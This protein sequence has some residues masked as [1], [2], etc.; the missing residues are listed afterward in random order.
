MLPGMLYL[1][2]IVAARG[3]NTV[4]LLLLATALGFGGFAPV[5][6]TI[7]FVTVFTALVGSGLGTV[8]LRNASIAY[9]RS[10]GEFRDL[11]RWLT[12]WTVV[13]GL[14]SVALSLLLAYPAAQ[15]SLGNGALWHLFAIAGL[16]VF[17]VHVSGVASSILLASKRVRYLVVANLV[18]GILVLIACAIAVRLRSAEMA[19]L[20][21]GLAASGQAAIVCLGVW[22]E[23]PPRLGRRNRDRSK[24]PTLRAIGSDWFAAS[25]AGTFLTAG[26]FISLALL[27]DSPIGVG[28]IGL[29]SVMLQMVNIFLF[30]PIQLSG[31]FFQS[32]V[33]HIKA[34]EPAEIWRLTVIIIVCGAAF[35]TASFLLV[36]L[37]APWV[38]IFDKIIVYGPM[39]PVVAALAITAGTLNAF[40]VNLYSAVGQYWRWTKFIVIGTCTSLLLVYLMR[41]HTV[42][43][44]LIGVT[45]GYWITA[46]C[47]ILFIRFDRR[48]IARVRPLTGS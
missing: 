44:G 17:C 8:A 46:F 20:G 16:S 24:T 43:A 5:A 12:G 1:G 33:R 6:A 30:V 40:L 38:S 2:G 18:F 9:L 28:A 34:G 26:Q 37:T 11:V 39:Q 7:S 32:L 36:Y 27:K 21:M 23:F 41:I 48:F 13:T 10:T 47:A 4:G 22:R 25:A 42:E 19:V 45:S 35:G 15:L 3:G 31:Y 14:G 29:F